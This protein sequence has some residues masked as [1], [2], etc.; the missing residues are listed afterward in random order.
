[1]PNY[2][3]AF[4]ALA[5]LWRF[6]TLFVSVRHEKHLKQRGAVEY[7][8]ANSTLLAVSHVLYYIA[9]VTEAFTKNES[10]NPPISLFG[11]G[12]YIASAIVLLLVMRSLANLWTVKI[13]ISPEH[14]LVKNGLFSLV[15]HPNYFLNIIPELFGFALALNAYWTL[16]VGIPLYMV[17]LT[18]RIRQEEKVMTA[19]FATYLL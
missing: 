16:L 11:I 4:I 5:F 15:R 17:P 19:K 14:K 18:I 6:W 12:L 2:L 7:G 3:I 8:A 1:M 9:A 10:V 13:I